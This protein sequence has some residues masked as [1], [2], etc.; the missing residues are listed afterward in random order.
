MWRPSSSFVCCAATALCQLPKKA[1]KGEFSEGLGPYPH[2]GRQHFCSWTLQCASSIKYL[3]EYIYSRR[4]N[5]NSGASL[6]DAQPPECTRCLSLCLGCARILEAHETPKHY[7]KWEA[8][9]GDG[10]SQRTS[11][12]FSFCLDLRHLRASSN[13][14]SLKGSA[15]NPGISLVTQ[16]LI[17]V[18]DLNFFNEITIASATACTL[19]CFDPTWDSPQKSV[20][21]RV[22]LE[23][24]TEVRL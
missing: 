16:F 7:R 10:R 3:R 17:Q 13:S 9:A 11:P 6:S 24:A 5:E 23:F 2:H 18:H 22:A 1:S 15:R 4:P 12:S 8:I 21:R 19:Q 14:I 20:S